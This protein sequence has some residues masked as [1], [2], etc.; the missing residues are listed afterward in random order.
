MALHVVTGGVGLLE[1][2]DSVV[3]TAGGLSYSGRGS[4]GALKLCNNGS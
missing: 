3:L 1:L 4:G 2:L